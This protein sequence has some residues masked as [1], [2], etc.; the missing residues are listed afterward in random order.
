MT[1]F[2]NQKVIQVGGKLTVM[3]MP[4]V[5]LDQ[6][7]HNAPGVIGN[8]R[9]VLT[10]VLRVMAG[11]TIAKT[12]TR[13]LSKY[14]DPQKTGLTEGDIRFVRRLL[15][16]TLTGLS[17]DQ[18]I[19]VGRHVS[20]DGS[21]VL[22]EVSYDRKLR[23]PYHSRAPR[24]GKGIK[25][26]VWGAIKLEVDC[27]DDEDYATRVLIHEATHKYAGAD[28]RS[29]FDDRGE[30]PKGRNTNADARINADTYAWFAMSLY[31]AE[32]ADIA[33]R[34]EGFAALPLGF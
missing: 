23:K 20:K 14:F 30:N 8:A 2:L 13:L 4:S 34:V 18:T 25:K 27:F 9:N 21:N 33:Q 17:G 26:T 15:V 6:S 32:L 5:G 16:V 24:L 31:H 11:P 22:G 3:C 29:Y 1:R 19:K 10:S 12:T 7:A 28:D